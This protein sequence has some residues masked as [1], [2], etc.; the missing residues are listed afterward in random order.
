VGTSFSFTET[1]RTVDLRFDLRA[2]SILAREDGEGGMA[3]GR[4][5]ALKEGE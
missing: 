2:G 1:L 5:S 4:I 3:W